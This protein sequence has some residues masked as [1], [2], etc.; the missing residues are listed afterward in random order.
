MKRHQNKSSRRRDRRLTDRFN[1]KLHEQF[2]KLTEEFASEYFEITMSSDFSKKEKEDKY[3]P[4]LAERFDKRWRDFIR[5]WIHLNR[6]DIR[7]EVDKRNQLLNRFS[8]F[9]KKYD[10]KF[11]QR[12]KP[13]DLTKSH[14]LEKIK[15]ALNKIGVNTQAKTAKGLEKRLEQLT[16]GQ[17]AALLKVL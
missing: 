10:D 11:E 13:A 17:L 6:K 4:N 2:T 3:L 14:D 5:R 15:E 8:D 16:A 1:E 9:A 12:T 7:L